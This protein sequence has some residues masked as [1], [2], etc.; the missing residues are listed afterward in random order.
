[1]G[2]KPIGS[3]AMTPAERQAKRRASL[4]KNFDAAIRVGLDDALLERLDN[5]AQTHGAIGRSEAV[6][7]LLA[8]A[9]SFHEVIEGGLGTMVVGLDVN[10]Q[11]MLDSWIAA[12]APDTSRPEALRR[13]L[14]LTKSAKP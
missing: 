3:V 9:L 6:R 13:I 7:R 11:Q 2:R 10:E 5:F 8:H 12:S 4:R 14:R 1:M